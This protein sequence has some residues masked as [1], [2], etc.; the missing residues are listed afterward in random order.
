MNCKM[1]YVR[2]SKKQQEA[3]APL[4]TAQE[5]LKK[6]PPAKIN[7][8]IYGA[9]DET[10]ERLCMNPKGYTQVTHAIRLL[11]ENGFNVKINYSATPANIDDMEKVFSYCENNGLIVQAATYMFPPVRKSTENIGH[12]FRFTAEESPFTTKGLPWHHISA[13]MA[14]ET[15]M[16]RWRSICRRTISCISGM[17]TVSLIGLS[18]LD[19]IHTR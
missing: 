2:M 6:C 10:Y 14:E 15:S 13:Y 9:S 12:N 1:C 5:W 4:H 3:I 19:R 8:T 7:I 18:R 17:R 11:K 16:R